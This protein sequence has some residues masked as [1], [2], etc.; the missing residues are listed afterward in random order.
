MAFDAGPIPTENQFP[1]QTLVACLAKIHGATID[2][3]SAWCCL[4]TGVALTRGGDL[5]D[6]QVEAFLAA[7]EDESPLTPPPLSR[8]FL[9]VANFGPF[10]ALIP[11][12]LRTINGQLSLIEW[13]PEVAVWGGGAEGRGQ[14]K[15]RAFPGA[16]LR[17]WMP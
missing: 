1:C 2:G 11:R 15:R 16:D 14:Y 9:P 6:V 5:L 7:S 4:A 10:L 13:A 12:A 17:H 8:R 3:T